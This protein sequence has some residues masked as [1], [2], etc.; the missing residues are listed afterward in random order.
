MKY[1]LHFTIILT[2]IMYKNNIIIIKIL[3]K[4][5]RFRLYKFS[6]F[7]NI[8]LKIIKLWFIRMI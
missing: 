5:I 1:F 8:I 7:S 2:I 4:F 3:F 6:P